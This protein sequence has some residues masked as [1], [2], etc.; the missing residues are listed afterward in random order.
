MPWVLTFPDSSRQKERRCREF[1]G[2]ATPTTTSVLRPVSCLVFAFRCL[3]FKA[4]GLGEPLL[5]HEDLHR[6][7]IG[8][9]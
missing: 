5:N 6:Q 2:L 7:T 9:A 8:D 4:L 3:L 1:A